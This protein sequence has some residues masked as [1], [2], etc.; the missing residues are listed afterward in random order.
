MRH[1]YFG[2]RLGRDTNARKALLMNLSTA[3]LERGQVT[4]TLAKAKFVRPYVEKLIT[5]AKRKNDLRGKRVIASRL[6]SVAFNKLF[7]DYASG[8]FQRS[9][10]YTR[11]VKLK[12]RLGDDAPMARIE[13]LPI[14]KPKKEEALKKQNDKKPTPKA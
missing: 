9:G 3:L 13:L 8:F 14:E 4:T 10:G 12:T 11:V 6:K 1:S 2:Q 7:G 5:H